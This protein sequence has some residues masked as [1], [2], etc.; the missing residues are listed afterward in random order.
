M[1]RYKMFSGVELTLLCSHL[2][3]FPCILRNGYKLAYRCGD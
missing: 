1:R 3:H 2:K